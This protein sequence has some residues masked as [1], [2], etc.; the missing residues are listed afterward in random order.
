MR[1]RER[2]RVSITV[3]VCVCHSVCVSLCTTRNGN[4]FSAESVA[5]PSN[6]LPGFG[7][8]NK[9][10]QKNAVGIATD[11]RRTARARAKLASL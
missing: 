5:W 6:S 7:N 8:N 3:C 9:T 1:E 4:F 2:E 11:I 10:K